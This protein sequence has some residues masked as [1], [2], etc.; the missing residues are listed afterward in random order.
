MSFAH[1]ISFN[2]HSNLDVVIIPV[3]CFLLYWLK[4]FMIIRLL[5]YRTGLGPQVS[6]LMLVTTRHGSLSISH[7]FFKTQL[8]S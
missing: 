3:L 6:E 2:S 1:I 5:G 7:K 4:F 8:G